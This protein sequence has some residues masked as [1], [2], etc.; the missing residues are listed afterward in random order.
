MV[1]KRV[2]CVSC[3][4]IPAQR[5]GPLPLVSNP[6]ALTMSCVKLSQFMKTMFCFE[7]VSV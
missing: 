1:Q 4:M 2:S 5:L 6:E 7:T 3:V